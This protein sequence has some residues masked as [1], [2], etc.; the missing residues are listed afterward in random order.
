MKKYLT[1]FRLRFATGVQYRM[2]SIMALTTQLIWGLMECLAF[3]A[4]AQASGGQMKM[5]YQAI[6]SYIWL[7][8]AFLAL[9]NTWAADNELFTMIRNGDIAYELCRPVSVYSMWFARITGGRCS[10][11]L[12]RCVPVLCCAFLMPSSY[13]MGLPVSV[14]AFFLFLLTMLLG[15]GVTIAFCMVVYM[16]CFFTIAPQGWRMVLTGAV[17]LLSGNLIPLPFFPQRYLRLAELLPFAY[18]Q[19]VPFRIYCG[20]LTGEAVLPMIGKQIFWLLTLILAGVG[21]WHPSE[22]FLR[23]GSCFR[24]L[25]RSENI[26]MGRFCFA[27]P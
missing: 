16:L 4:I 15:M 24:I 14:G 22:N 17:D 11:A 6:V 2:A 10:E 27:F 1:F 13:R 18:M 3:R 20:D 7:K 12:L 19:N 8:E 23:S 26:P 21:V 9:F 5:E 25:K